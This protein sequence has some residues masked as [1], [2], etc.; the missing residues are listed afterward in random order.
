VKTEV[1]RAQPPAAARPRPWFTSGRFLLLLAGLVVIYGY[2]WQVTQIRLG[3]L[4][5]GVQFVRPFLRDLVRPEVLTR[6]TTTQKVE[7][8]MSIDPSVAPESLPPDPSGARLTV[9]RQV[10]VVGGPVTVSGTG[11]RPNTSGRL[12]WLNRIGN[13][14]EVATVTTDA[15]GAFTATI[16]VP[17]VFQGPDPGAQ[18]AQQRLSAEFTWPVG[19]LK[20]S[21]TLLLVLEKVVETVFLALMG[22]TFAIVIAVPLSFLG[23]RNLMARNPVGSAIYYVVRMFFNI[24]RSIEPLI[25]A[26]VFTV[27]VGLGPFAGVMAL[28][29]HSIASL[30]KLYSEQIE[31]IDPGPIEAITATGASPLQ[32]VRYAVVPQIVPPFIAFT[33][34]RW[35]IN[36]RMSTVIGFVGGGGIG[37]ILQQY[38]NLLQYR[39]AA[40][41][42]WAITIVV[43]AMDYFS[44]WIREKVV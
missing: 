11:F 39:Q 19:G 20:L 21:R 3:E 2:G 25:L 13:P 41:A 15:Q 43:S 23:A 17:E 42:V 38:I 26:I 37:F 4:V 24:M 44:A 18:S 40:T 6:D 27:W 10:T 9:S 35:D 1:I 31:S 30:G 34:Y 16:R 22:T 8:G 28:G 12:M 33:I 14:V 32:V 36:V 7:I 29:L 5:V